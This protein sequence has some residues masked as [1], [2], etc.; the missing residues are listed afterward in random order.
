MRHG[1]RT[2]ITCNLTDKQLRDRYGLRIDD[3]MNEMFE[4]ATVDGV[5]L[6]K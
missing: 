1:V 4:F 3:R 2:I 5:S 6:R